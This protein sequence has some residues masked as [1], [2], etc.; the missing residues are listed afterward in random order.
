MPVSSQ[1]IARTTARDPLLCKVIDCINVGWPASVTE[2]DLKPFFDRRNELTVHQGC[3][4]F[5]MRVIVPAKLRNLL[6]DEL[7]EG[8]PGIVR[9]KQLA[10]SYVWWPSIE[11]D[12]EH[13]V[14][15]CVSC[16]EQ[17]CEPCKAPLHP[18]SWPTAPWQRVHIDFAGPFL[19]AM[20]LV[21]VDAH[22]KWPEVFVMHSTTSEATV[23]RLRELFARF[24]FP[25]TIVTDNGP[26]FTSEEFK[27]FVKELGCRHV[28]TAPYHP[29]SNGLAERFIQTLKNALR[30]SSGADTL[31]LRLHKFLLNYR[32]SP[33]ST[34]NESPANLLLG[35][36]LRNQLDV[37][38]PAVGGRVA[39]NQFKQ[40]VARPR[41]DRH[42]A[43]GDQVMARNYRGRP[44]WVPGVV[45][46]QSGPV[47]FNV[48]ATTPRGS[49]TWRRHKDQLLVRTTDPDREASDQEG[50]EFLAFPPSVD[51]VTSSAPTTSGPAASQEIQTAGARRYPTRDRRPPDRYQAGV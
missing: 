20:F 17:R 5:G 36:R 21:V 35:R 8:H 15:A 11:A 4:M 42:I 13:R 19:H 40:S 3:I 27:L 6:L 33:H 50:Y 51:P 44:N 16:Q 49:F 30:K 29:S 14:K 25:E 45:V 10:R 46:E 43:V 23:D 7:H 47:S 48:R 9:S 31:Q 34:T 24:G 18:W 39:Y 37:V 38:K 12:L 1:D 22:S 28:L 26:Q 32:N 2:N 41:R